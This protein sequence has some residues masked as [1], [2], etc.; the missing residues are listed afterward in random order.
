MKKISA[1][2]FALLKFQLLDWP[3]IVTWLLITNRN[4]Q[5]LRKFN[6]ITIYKFLRPYSCSSSTKGSPMLP[7][8]WMHRL[9]EVGP[10]EGCPV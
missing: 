9:Y 4:G 10:T 7:A 5:C 2:T 3:S 1:K 8:H 6:E